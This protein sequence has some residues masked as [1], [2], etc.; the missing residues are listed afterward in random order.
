MKHDTNRVHILSDLIYLFPKDLSLLVR[1]ATVEIDPYSFLIESFINS[2]T[3]I[4]DDTSVKLC[5]NICHRMVTIPSDEEESNLD[6][7]AS[8]FI[9]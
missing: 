1:E 6:Y 3:S 9:I 4:I 7:F 8:K 2:S 5:P